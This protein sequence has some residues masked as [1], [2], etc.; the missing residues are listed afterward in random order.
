MVTN[1]GAPSFSPCRWACSKIMKPKRDIGVKNETAVIGE[2]VTPN[3]FGV[4]KVFKFV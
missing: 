3:E 2:I 1:Q 4:L